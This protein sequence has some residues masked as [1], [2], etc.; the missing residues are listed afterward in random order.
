MFVLFF[1]IY[2]LSFWSANVV[3]SFYV[4]FE[5]QSKITRIL[6]SAIVLIISMILVLNYLQFSEPLFKYYH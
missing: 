3:D 4:F 1:K 2:F 6:I 5:D